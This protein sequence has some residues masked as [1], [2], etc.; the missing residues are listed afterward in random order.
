MGLWD[1]AHVRRQ[2][3]PHLTLRF[4]GDSTTDVLKNILATYAARNQPM[5]ATFNLR[6]DGIHTFPDGDH[7]AVVWAGVAGETDALRR[8]QGGLNEAAIAEGL[9]PQTFPFQPHITIAH[10]DSARLN[11]RQAQ[12]GKAII[13]ELDRDPPFH[14]P[15]AEASLTAH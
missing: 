6:L 9:P 1:T 13:A 8:L 10:I 12:A 2:Y 7:P 5:P 11:E 15:Q 3:Q 14:P 4:I